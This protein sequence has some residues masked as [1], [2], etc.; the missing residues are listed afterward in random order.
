MSFK[1][2]RCIKVL[3][4]QG[5]R[6]CSDFTNVPGLVLPFFLASKYNPRN[7]HLVMENY[8]QKYIFK[9]KIMS[10][11]AIMCSQLARHDGQ[12]TRV[13]GLTIV[14]PSECMSTSI[15]IGESLLLRWAP[16]LFPSFSCFSRSLPEVSE[17]RNVQSLEGK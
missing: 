7:V 2:E 1:S 17:T 15:A 3:I 9:L 12:T 14:R 6:T 5:A 16:L 11:L 10:A 4:A 13:V 8:T